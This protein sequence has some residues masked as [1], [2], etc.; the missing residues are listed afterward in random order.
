MSE[1]ASGQTVIRQVSCVRSG[2]WVLDQS[3]FVI[4]TSY[5]ALSAVRELREVFDLET[6]RVCYLPLHC[7]WSHEGFC[8]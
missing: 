3:V 4:R 6:T 1:I 5:Y 2:L 8:R 7:I